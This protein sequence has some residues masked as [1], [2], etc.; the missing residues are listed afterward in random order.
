LP[1][2]TVLTS[3]SKS[4]RVTLSTAEARGCIDL[5]AQVCP[6][7]LD[8]RTVGGR[9]WVKMGESGEVGLGEVRRRVKAELEK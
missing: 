3:L 4:S 9:E 1:L 6:G 5:L 8:V 7:F 2:S